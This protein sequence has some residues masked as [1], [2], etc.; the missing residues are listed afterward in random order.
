MESVCGPSRNSAALQKLK[1]LNIYS[2]DSQDAAVPPKS[3]P[4]HALRIHSDP[5]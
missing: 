3:Y 4:L 1:H 5:S 2:C